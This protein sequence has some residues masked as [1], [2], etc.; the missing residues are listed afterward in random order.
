MEAVAQ[1]HFL[2]HS[3][4]SLIG[5]I[6]LLAIYY[7]I[8]RRFS[9][10]IGE[11][12]NYTRVDRGLLYLSF[13]LTTWVV[14]GFWNYFQ[15]VSNI[16]HENIDLLLAN[17]FSIFNNLFFLLALYYFDNAPSFIYRNKKS[18]WILTAMVI[19][20][21]IA[22]IVLPQS[23]LEL[24]GSEI[25]IHV[26]P[27]L[28][29]SLF[30]SGLLAYTFYQT[31]IYRG[32]PVVAIISVCIVSTLF[33]SQIPEL[34]ENGHNQFAV[35]LLKLISKTSLIILF[36]VL[37]ASW[38]IEL[39]NTA[40]PAEIRLQFSDWSRIVLS[41]PSKSIKQVEIDFGSKTTQFKNLLK[42]SIRRKYG[43]GNSQC[44]DVS[45]GGEIKSQ[46]YVSRIPDNIN[47]IL[48]LDGDSKLDRKDIFTFLGEGK[49]RLRLLP[50]AIEI[51]EGL[52]H[53]FLNLSENQPYQNIL[54]ENKAITENHKG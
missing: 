45:A 26:I 43:I 35:H 22:S 52:L 46:A 14:A 39:A 48:N 16:D 23:A 7:N 20:V 38:V 8:K 37:A 19:L 12:G 27:D 18:N 28:V 6:L 30:L 29:F 41:I 47:E 10:Q 13:A 50:D 34:F 11:D 21:A 17:L 25:R 3:A 2:A 5:A 9:A 40:K 1:F 15:G 49:Y 4:I 33:M 51:D 36:L 31:F 44:I 24:M 32:L 54:K 53:E 42:F